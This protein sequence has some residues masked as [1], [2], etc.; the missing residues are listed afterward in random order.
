MENH[1]PTG[2]TDVLMCL[3]FSNLESELLILRDHLTF[4]AICIC[5]H[6]LW[7][8]GYWNT[9]QASSRWAH[10]RC[11]YCQRI[12]TSWFCIPCQPLSECSKHKYSTKEMSW[13]A[14]KLDN[15]RKQMRKKE[16]GQSKVWRAQR[17]HH[18]L[19]LP[20]NLKVSGRIWLADCEK[21][22]DRKAV[23]WKGLSLSRQNMLWCS[24]AQMRRG[25]RG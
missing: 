10:W 16:E 4:P 23:S 5:P 18:A 13:D 22:I 17:R 1:D 7:L 14:A 25:E 6:Q 19:F 9:V 15:G 2:F 8:W 21:Q 24:E 3:T 11:I 12:Y 20:V